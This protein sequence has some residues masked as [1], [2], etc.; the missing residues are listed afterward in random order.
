[1]I[2]LRRSQIHFQLRGLF[3]Y[4]TL[5]LTCSL[6]SQINAF[7]YFGA[8]HVLYCGQGP[9]SSSQNRSAMCILFKSTCT[10]ALLS[11]ECIVHCWP[12]RGGGARFTKKY[13]VHGVLGAGVEEGLDL[14]GKKAAK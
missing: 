1:M 8:L 10:P 9:S 5:V 3:I 6:D 4:T 13:R 14:Q 12:G 2:L 7:L 11:T